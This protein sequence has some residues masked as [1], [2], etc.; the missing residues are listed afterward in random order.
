MNSWIDMTT[1]KKIFVKIAI[2]IIE[3]I[4]VYIMTIVDIRSM[5]VMNM[6]MNFIQLITKIIKETIKNA[7]TIVTAKEIHAM[8]ANRGK[9]EEEALMEIKA[10]EGGDSTIE[11]MVTCL[12]AGKSKRS[13]LEKNMFQ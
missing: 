7:I 10:R 5:T 13:S 4:I 2:N 9:L 11:M 12:V 8:T 1:M 6:T 3:K